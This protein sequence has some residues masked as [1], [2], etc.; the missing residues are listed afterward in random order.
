MWTAIQTI[1]RTKAGVPRSGRS[2]Q[3]F[4]GNASADLIRGGGVLSAN[5]AREKMRIEFAN[6][7][8]IW[9]NFNALKAGARKRA[10]PLICRQKARSRTNV[11]VQ[12]DIGKTLQ[13]LKHQFGVDRLITIR[14][15]AFADHEP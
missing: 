2:A 14:P 9:R 4:A 8:D 3:R 12:L 1:N 7:F 5:R 10:P 13:D 11:G 6:A 15:Q